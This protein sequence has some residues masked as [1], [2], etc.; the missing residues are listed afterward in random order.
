MIFLTVSATVIINSFSWNAN[1]LKVSL[2]AP[3]I[4]K[5]FNQIIHPFA[6]SKSAVQRAVIISGQAVATSALLAPFS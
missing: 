2:A 3:L 4:C 1:D 5:P 6:P